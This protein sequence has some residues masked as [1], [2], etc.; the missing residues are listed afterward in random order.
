ME[1]N[2]YF[3]LI[4]VIFA[5]VITLGYVF[6]LFHRVS[7]VPINDDKIETISTSTFTTEQ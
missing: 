1:F 2:I 3:P 4:L 7:R 6:V 5:A